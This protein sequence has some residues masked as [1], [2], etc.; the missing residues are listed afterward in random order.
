MY[1]SSRGYNRLVTVLVAVLVATSYGFD[2]VSQF[3]LNT[4]AGY[5]GSLASVVLSDRK[6]PSRDW[7]TVVMGTALSGYGSVVAPEGLASGVLGLV[8]GTSSA[9]YQEALGGP[10]SGA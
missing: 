3:Y 6:D 9:A 2:R 10:G 8:L 7:I 4:L 1:G 5:T